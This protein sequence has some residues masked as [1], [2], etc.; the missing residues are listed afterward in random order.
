[1]NANV[2]IEKYKN[3]KIEIQVISPRMPARK[4]HSGGNRSGGC[5]FTVQGN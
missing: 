4:N 5:S 3:L 2:K 1:M